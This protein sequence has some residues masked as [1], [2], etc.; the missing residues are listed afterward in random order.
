MDSTL[1]GGCLMRWL[2]SIIA[3]LGLCRDS[4]AQQVLSFD[5]LTNLLSK[6]NPLAWSQNGKAKLRVEGYLVAGDWGAARDAFWVRSTNL[7][8]W[9]VTNALTTN[10]GAFFQFPGSTNGYLVFPD[11][12]VGTPEVDPRWFGMPAPQWFTNIQ[13]RTTGM[14]IVEDAQPAMQAAVDFLSARGG[15]VVRQPAGVIRVGTSVRVKPDVSIVGANPT[16][17]VQWDA[18]TLSMGLSH[19]LS[20]VLGSKG[21]TSMPNW[22]GQTYP[23]FLADAADYTNKYSPSFINWAGDT[24]K[25]ARGGGTIANLVIVPEYG[26]SWAG[27]NYPAS[28][29]V[30]NEVAY[31]NLRGN[32][33]FGGLAPGL[34]LRGAFGYVVEKNL[35]Q[36]NW[37]GG[38]FVTDTSDGIFRHN[39]LPD[40]KGFGVFIYK[41]NSHYLEANEY[42]N[43]NYDLVRYTGAST[44]F[45]N[46]NYIAALL[47]VR[48]NFTADPSSDYVSGQIGTSSGMPIV[49]RGTNLP[50]GLVT[51][52]IYF[53]R[54]DPALTN[55]TRY[56][57]WTSSGGALGKTPSAVP[58]DITSTG[59]TNTWWV[60]SPGRSA[61]MVVAW[62]CEEI[63]V[64]GGRA[65]MPINIGVMFE[66]VKRGAIS[67]VDVWD[68]GRQAKLLGISLPD[69]DDVVAFWL[70]NT[71]GIEVVGNTQNAGED[72]ASGGVGGI[73]PRDYVGLRLQSAVDTTVVGNYFDRMDNGIQMDAG[74][75]INRLASQANNFGVGAMAAIVSDSLVSPGAFSGVL[76]RK[77]NG[78]AGT[79]PS[80]ATNLVDFSIA[81]KFQL[82]TNLPGNGQEPIL[83]LTSSTNFAAPAA[84]TPYGLTLVQYFDNAQQR[85]FFYIRMFGATTNDWRDWYAGINEYRGR[86]IEAIVQRSTNGTMQLW[87][88]RVSRTL[89][90]GTAGSAP[91]TTQ[92]IY[93]PYL[94]I[95]AYDVHA[96]SNWIYGVSLAR[97]TNWSYDAIA[98]GRPWTA[99][100][101]NIVALW[102]FDGAAA[103]GV[104][105]LSG[106]GV[107]GRLASQLSAQAPTWGPDPSY[108]VQAGAGITVT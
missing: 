96:R 59:G 78:I 32:V 25:Y 40:N 106:N 1:G 34:Y 79:L 86:H 43:P 13:V 107:H 2:I 89:S 83:H 72:F 44:V 49:L 81:V 22:N 100:Q 29:V 85:D 54:S 104:W 53:I 36:G 6:P 21:P 70:S 105:D 19:G 92:A 101:T 75:T 68:M 94:T 17:A 37:I 46:D 8:L 20:V 41:A 27:T 38:A 65:D 64:R 87:I 24:V 47:T 63:Y 3:V 31:I 48:S 28:P 88:D 93:A 11:C 97:G 60:D 42:W 95:G 50:G 10:A 33:L 45:T 14:Q 39:R 35:I 23:V 51:N 66:D 99:P 4:V 26:W 52:T 108:R 12:Y 74:S 73:L 16:T 77:T 5:S 56:T 15:G 91:A 61:A 18:G 80:S 84:R 57:L 67:G 90:Q 58:I 69:D 62:S 102:N 82:S 9:G 103:S 7:V 30:V 55:N 76:L 71:Y 98:K